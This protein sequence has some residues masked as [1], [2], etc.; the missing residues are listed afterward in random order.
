[1]P[2]PWKDFGVEKL[3]GTVIPNGDENVEKSYMTPSTTGYNKWMVNV[4][5]TLGA[6]GQKWLLTMALKLQFEDGDFLPIVDPDFQDAFN[7]LE[8]KYVTVQCVVDA[9][10]EQSLP[11]TNNPQHNLYHGDHL[12]VNFKYAIESIATFSAQMSLRCIDCFPHI[13]GRLTVEA[14]PFEG[15]HEF[16]LLHLEYHATP[17]KLRRH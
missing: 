8:F 16:R 3:R 4:K 15:L 1:M 17:M 2:S 10:G 14:H 11:Q 7:G 13:Y 6:C 12:D 9:G 5:K